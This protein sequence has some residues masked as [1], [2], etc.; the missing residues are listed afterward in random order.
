L[1]KNI[2]NMNQLAS[3]F[4]EKLLTKIVV[5]RV[6]E[7]KPKK[8][9]VKKLDTEEFLEG[10]ET[11]EI[12]GVCIYTGISKENKKEIKRRIRFMKSVI[13]E[14]PLSVLESSVLS[15]EGR[16]TNI[17]F[18][19]ENIDPFYTTPSREFMDIVKVGCN[20]WETY[21]FPNIYNSPVL[22]DMI[23]SI[24]ALKGKKIFIGC[25]CQPAID[26]SRVFS[27][28][29]TLSENK[30]LGIFKKYINTE[31]LDENVSFRNRSKK[32]I[33]TF[34]NMF[35]FRITLKKAI[36]EIF[37]IV[38]ELITS[39]SDR[40]KCMEYINSIVDIIV[41]F[42]SYARNCT[43]WKKEQYESIFS[44][45]TVKKVEEEVKRKKQ[46]TGLYFNS[47]VTLD[48]YNRVNRNTSKIKLFRTGKVQ[49]PGVKY[50]NMCDII[51]P[52]KLLCKFWSKC[53]PEDPEPEIKYL[54]SNMRNYKCK[55][56]NPVYRILLNRLEDCLYFEKD[57]PISPI[58]AYECLQFTETFGFD[59]KTNLQIFKYYGYS[60]Y[61]VS[62][63]DNTDSYPGLVV[64]FNRPIPSKENKKITIKIL[65]SG[66]INFDG[67][68]SELEAYEMYYWVQFILLKY[69]NEVIHNP[70]KYQAF[71]S[72]DDEYESIYDSE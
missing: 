47:Q 19:E 29:K 58:S 36:D 9:S 14:N 32:I 68:N 43:C 46:G 8:K 34:D 40:I 67:N 64:K 1:K 55:M 52:L 45:P 16:I 53:F 21:I 44:R 6:E 4:Q 61:K 41:V 10:Y 51:E 71:I 38:E 48:I 2:E 25:Y 12:D 72:D 54:L 15:I 31:N 35:N 11:M 22:Q 69:Q 23:L 17:L 30:D 66:K 42:T 18:N 39:K 63:I 7:K 62:E 50:P 65:S 33:K 13:P 49:V 59:T 57:L 70:K 3:L 20:F 56:S 37:S 27:M 26:T 5:D 24:K 60:F 28:L